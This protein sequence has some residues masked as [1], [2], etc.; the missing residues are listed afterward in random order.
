MT[1]KN[2]TWLGEDVGTSPGPSFNIWGQA[3]SGTMTCYFKFDKGVPLLIDDEAG[4]PQQRQL[5]QHVL[6][7]AASNRFF[8]VADPEPPEEIEEPPPEEDAAA[9]TN[10]DQPSPSR[11]SAAAAPHAVK[12][13]K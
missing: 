7:Q 2:V 11:R 6:E 9:F 5:A 8:T 12:R 13:K 4:T 1:A 10:D 3:I